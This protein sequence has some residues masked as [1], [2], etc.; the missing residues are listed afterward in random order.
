MYLYY[1]DIALG[2]YVIHSIF[3]SEYIPI[4]EILEGE[5]HR[6][7]RMVDGYT[8]FAKRSAAERV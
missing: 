2:S 5:R 1:V 4:I 8:L 3:L 6:L 7:F